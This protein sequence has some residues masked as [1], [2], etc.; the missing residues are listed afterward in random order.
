M[1]SAD[2][3]CDKSK[4]HFLGWWVTQKAGVSALETM[5]LICTFYIFSS[6]LTEHQTKYNA[7]S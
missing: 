6:S 7:Q 2:A 4:L 1:V 3:K 5:A